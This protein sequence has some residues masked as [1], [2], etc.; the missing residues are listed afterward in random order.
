MGSHHS[1][2]RIFFDTRN[3]YETDPRLREAVHRSTIEARLYMPGDGIGL[4]EADDGQ[5]H[6]QV[7]DSRTFAAAKRLHDED[8]SRHIAVLNFASAT[9]PGG[10]VI[11]GARA[12][13][14]S[15]C[16]CST[17]YP[18]LDQQRF[19]NGYY[20]YHRDRGDFRYTDACIY[21][22]GVVV[23]KDDGFYPEPLPEDEWYT[24]DVI[25]CAAPNLYYSFYYG[26]DYGVSDAELY[27]IHASRAKRI[28]EVAAVNG[29]DTL[30]LGAFG[31]GAFRND[32]W[33]VARAFR[34]VLAE[35]GGYFETIEFAIAC[36]PGTESENLRAFRSTLLGEGD[37]PA[38]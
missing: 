19:W 27:D 37:R 23:F 35:M 33:V 18:T 26:S 22:P 28:C 2:A 38:D 29:V 11:D 4:P 14:E 30:V 32:P 36:A 6:L 34:D 21:S 1:L 20:R 3:S 25:T 10:G 15:L 13:E 17:L 12:Q 8:P 9:N 5:P 31:C 24:V 16:R 7:T